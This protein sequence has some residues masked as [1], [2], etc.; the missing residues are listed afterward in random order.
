MV[1]R[2]L[3]KLIAANNLEKSFVWNQEDDLPIKV[4]LVHDDTIIMFLNLD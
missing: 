1:K 2:V 4:S 3:Q